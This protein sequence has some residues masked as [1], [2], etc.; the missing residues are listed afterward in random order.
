MQSPNWVFTLNNYSDDDVARI[1]AGSDDIVYVVAGREIGEGGTPHLQ[2]FVRFKTKRRLAAVKSFVGERAHCEC[3]RNLNASITYCKKDGDFFEVGQLDR[4]PGSR[5]DLDGFK[6]AVASGMFDLRQIREEHSEV[7][8]KYTRFCLQYIDDH[9]PEREQEVFPLYPWQATL[10]EALKRDADSR[11]ITFVV[12]LV[13]NKGKTW[14]AHYFC[15]L[16]KNCQVLLPGRKVDMAMTLDPDVRVLFLDAPR[17]KNGEYIQYDF[18][19]DV[20]NGYVFSSKYESRIKKLGKVHVV[21][22]MNEQPDMTKLSLD[23]YN[24]INL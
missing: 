4:K 14:F 16:H 9:R 6:E 3:S 22:L 21:V 17:S 12:D 24:I 13:G 15:S 18:L 10:S 20:K 1:Q 7:Y 5:T 11:T 2:G 19:E 23:R 8:A